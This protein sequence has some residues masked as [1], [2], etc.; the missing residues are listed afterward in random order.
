MTADRVFSW[1]LPFLTA[2]HRR[3]S[4]PQDMADGQRGVERV[5]EASKGA[6][7]VLFVFSYMN[8]VM[9]RDRFESREGMNA[10]SI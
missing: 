5:V 4:S 10:D 1:Q 8:V 7:S 2:A 6:F 3:T 9:S